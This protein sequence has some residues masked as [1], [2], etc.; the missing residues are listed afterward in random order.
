MS[1]MK[2]EKN[3]AWDDVKKKYYVTLYFG[4]D[5]S[6]TIIKKTVTTTN[7]KEAQSIL[8]EHNKKMEAGTAVVPNKTIL[9]DYAR[10]CIEYKALT[11]SQTTIYGYRNILKNHITPYFKKKSIQD[12]TPKDIQDY[13]TT[14]ASTG[15]SLQ[16]VKKHVAL[17]Y[18]VFQNAYR[19]RIINENPI[20]RLERIKAPSSKMECMNALETADLCSSLIGTQLEVPVKLAAYLGLRRGEVLGLK[21]GHVDFDNGIIHICNTRTEAGNTVIEKQP[22]TERSLRQLQLTPEL[23]DLLKRQQKKQVTLSR[24]THETQDY[25]V[26]MDNGKAFDPNYLS[27]AFHKHLVKNGY[28]QIRF[29]DLRHSFASIANS[30]GTSLRDISEAMGHSNISTTSDIYTHEFSQTKAKAVNAVALSIEHAKSP[31]N[32]CRELT[33]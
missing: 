30:A 10:E 4:K 23:V 14:K 19:S 16:S 11:L 33:S 29:H 27:E 3:I 13:I 12:I 6:G 31:G 26:T 21:W 18:S 24:W 7:K 17:L 2:I 22:K 8:R 28:K 1:R 20:D 5:D 25:V 32:S 9:V 15:I